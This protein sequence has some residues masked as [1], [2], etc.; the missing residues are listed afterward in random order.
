MTVKDLKTVLDKCVNQDAEIN[1]KFDGTDAFNN[2]YSIHGSTIDFIGEDV[3]TNEAVD[4]VDVVIK[5][6]RNET[7]I[8]CRQI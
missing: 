1:F 4:S 5:M 6:R 8:K 2:V 3:F 7:F